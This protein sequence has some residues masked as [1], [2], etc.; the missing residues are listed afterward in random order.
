MI[1]IIQ[2]CCIFQVLMKSSLLLA[3]SIYSIVALMAAVCCIILPVETKGKEMKEGLS[4]KWSPLKRD[5]NNFLI[6]GRLLFKCDL[7]DSCRNTLICTHVFCALFFLFISTNYWR[8]I[9]F[10]RCIDCDPYFTTC[11]IV[12]F[13]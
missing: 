4:K 2:S 6:A 1:V 7:L 9:S 12:C 10:I 5:E 3:M 8:N 13:P 11:A